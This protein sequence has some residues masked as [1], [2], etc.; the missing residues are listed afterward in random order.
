MTCAQCGQTLKDDARFCP[1]CGASQQPAAGPAE[2]PLTSAQDLAAPP[3]AR[4]ISTKLIVIAVSAALL[5]FL[6]S[7]VALWLYFFPPG[8]YVS[9]SFRKPHK[10]LATFVKTIN[11][12]YSD[13]KIHLQP[14]NRNFYVLLYEKPASNHATVEGTAIWKEGD[15]DTILGLACCAIDD[16]NF[17]ALMISGKGNYLLNTYTGGEWY[18]LTGFLRLP[19]SMKIQKGVP[20]KLK[21]VTEGDY[22]SAFLNDALLIR[23]LDAFQH[24][25]RS[26]IYAQGGKAGSTA[27]DFDDFKAK[28]NS[29]FQKEE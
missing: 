8:V 21:I 13:G 15:E 9:D 1:A 6:G 7:I 14:P 2:H 19:K 22:I 17:T 11:A 10:D 23:M 5:L 27:I 26:G 20:Y 25:G 29:L 24:N 12:N 4:K 28:K 3:H 18:D 16:N